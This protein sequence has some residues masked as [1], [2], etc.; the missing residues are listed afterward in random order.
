MWLHFFYVSLCW[1]G[2]TICNLL[3][4]CRHCPWFKARC[5]ERAGRDGAGR[6]GGKNHL[7]AAQ[8]LASL[9]KL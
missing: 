3:T 7:L 4:E 2:F 1:I 9:S 6:D 8:A 5:V